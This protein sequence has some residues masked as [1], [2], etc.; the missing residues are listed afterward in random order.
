MKNT[1]PDCG[2]EEGE[3]HQEGCDW[4]R[5][6]VCKNGQQLLSCE[7]HTWGEF[8]D[9]IREPFFDEEIFHC[10]RC[11][12]IAPSTTNIISNEEWKSLCGL[13]YPLDC[14]MC[15]KCMDF[16]QNKREKLKGGQNGNVLE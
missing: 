11:G 13:T 12:M 14:V 16:I 6:P 3:L 1:C 7:K 8:P 2:V 5:C 9:S 15:K 4:E 10:A